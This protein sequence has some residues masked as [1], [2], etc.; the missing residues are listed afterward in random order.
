M[1]QDTITKAK[2]LAA[3]I[4]RMVDYHAVASIPTK[5]DAELQRKA[6]LMVGAEQRVAVAL[7]NAI[8]KGALD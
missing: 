3:A 6:E 5:T 2:L 7:E 4:C 1:D 8:D